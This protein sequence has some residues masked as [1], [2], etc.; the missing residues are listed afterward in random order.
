MWLGTNCWIFWGVRVLI[1]KMRTATSTKLRV[2]MRT[3]W[4]AMCERLTEHMV[5][6]QVLLWFWLP[7]AE[8]PEES[9][10]MWVLLSAAPRAPLISQWVAWGW[11]WFL[12]AWSWQKAGD[13]IKMEVAE[14]SHMTS[15][16][17]PGEWLPAIFIQIGLFCFWTCVSERNSNCTRLPR[18][19]VS[20]SL[21]IHDMCE[22]GFK[23]ALAGGREEVLFGFFRLLC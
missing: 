1:P 7:H 22:S 20:Q 11:M 21:L 23:T 16:G 18:V 8:V 4:G 15:P 19:F 3:G 17:V 13:L 12:A 10:P 9:W 5:C 6:G 14:P 2:V